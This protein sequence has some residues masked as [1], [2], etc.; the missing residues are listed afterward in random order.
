MPLHSVGMHPVVVGG[1]IPTECV[2]GTVGGISTDRSIP[3]E[4]RSGRHSYGRLKPQK[5]GAI[6]SVG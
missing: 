6:L 2:A 4:C 1:R 5:A 3:T